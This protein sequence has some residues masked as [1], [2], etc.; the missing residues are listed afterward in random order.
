MTPKSEIEKIIKHISYQN[1]IDKGIEFLWIDG[2]KFAEWLQIGWVYIGIGWIKMYEF[3]PEKEK[4]IEELYEL[5]LKE[6]NDN[7]FNN[8]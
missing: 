3:I 1:Y 4:S 7:I 8:K 6:Q 5:F 2:F